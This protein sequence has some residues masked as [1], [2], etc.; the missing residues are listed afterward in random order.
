MTKLIRYI[1]IE[2][3]KILINGEVQASIKRGDILEI[4]SDGI[5]EPPVESVMNAGFG[6]DEPLDATNVPPMPPVKPPKKDVDHELTRK[7]KIVL[8]ILKLKATTE[9]HGYGIDNLLMHSCVDNANTLIE[10]SDK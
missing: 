7:D 10:A 5:Y 8:E 2:D 9:E 1:S 4:M 3:S 6:I